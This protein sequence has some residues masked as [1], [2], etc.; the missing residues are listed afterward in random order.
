GNGYLRKGMLDETIAAFKKVLEIEPD[1]AEAHRDLGA[2]YEMK[3]MKEA[4]DREFA[5]YEKLVSQHK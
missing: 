1:C 4:A 3:E 2:A 5:I